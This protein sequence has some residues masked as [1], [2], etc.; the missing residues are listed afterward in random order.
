MKKDLW[1]PAIALVTLTLGY[2]VLVLAG[3]ALLPERVAIHFGAAGHAD[4][5]APRAS[6][7]VFFEA[8]ALVPLIFLLLALLMRILP[9][10]TFNVPN[11]DYWLAPERR[12]ETVAIIAGQLLWVACLMNLFLMGIFGL[13][14]EAN[15]MTPPRL[16][17]N[18]FLPLLMLF[19]GGTI[20][21]TGVFLRR[22]RKPPA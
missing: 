20:A 21:W 13:T 7:T 1:I 16:P 22:F 11:R 19:I 9:A 8:L 4:G 18:L 3:S 5:W 12:D 10:W 2:L 14:I 17:M 6:A 15:R